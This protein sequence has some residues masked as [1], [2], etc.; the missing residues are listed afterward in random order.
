VTTSSTSSGPP[1]VEHLLNLVRNSFRRPSG[2]HLLKLAGDLPSGD[3]PPRPSLATMK[4]VKNTSRRDLDLDLDSSFLNFEKIYRRC[5]NHLTADGPG[6]AS[7]LFRWL[8]KFDCKCNYF[9]S[10]LLFREVLDGYTRWQWFEPS[11]Y[12]NFAHMIL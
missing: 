11:S 7:V 12:I 5:T 2:D 8:V 4:N 6:R 3:P 9:T 1:S 10:L